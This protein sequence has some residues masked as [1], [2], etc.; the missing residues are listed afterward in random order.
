MSLGL[1]QWY[2][3][4]STGIGISK[5]NWLKKQKLADVDTDI[6]LD[7]NEDRSPKKCAIKM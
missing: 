1:N 5:K 3:L 2:P 4:V 7:K 6:D